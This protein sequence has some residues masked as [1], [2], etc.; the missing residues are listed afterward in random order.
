MYKTYTEKYLF[1]TFQKDIAKHVNKWESIQ[2][3]WTR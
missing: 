3:L 2:Y 1:N